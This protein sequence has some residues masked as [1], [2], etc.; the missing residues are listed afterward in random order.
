MDPTGQIVLIFQGRRR[1]PGV[2]PGVRVLAEGVVGTR[3][4]RLAMTNPAYSILP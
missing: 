1:V 3:G 2:E 4:R